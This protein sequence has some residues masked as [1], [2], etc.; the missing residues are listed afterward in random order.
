MPRQLVFKSHTGT[1]NLHKTPTNMRNVT[2]VPTPQPAVIATK[3]AKAPFMATTRSKMGSPNRRSNQYKLKKSAVKPAA[4]PE[5]VVFTAQRESKCARFVDSV[6]RALP[7]LKPYQPN[8]KIIV[9]SIF[10]GQGE[11]ERRKTAS[12]HDV[13]RVS[14][15]RVQRQNLSRHTS[16]L[17]CTCSYL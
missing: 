12:N 16:F 8:H 15:L 11:R 10:F 2:H 5:R 13:H 6:I 1:T 14:G 7:A 17:I 3:P 4:P 9:P